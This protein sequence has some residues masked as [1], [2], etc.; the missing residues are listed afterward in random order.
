V[1]R[2]IAG[3]A[4]GL[5]LLL[6]AP[7]AVA[8]DNVPPAWAGSRITTTASV[9]TNKPVISA[10][11]VRA[12]N[13]SLPYQLNAIT[14]FTTPSGLP[15]GC[16][17]A[18]VVEYGTP[19]VFDAAS[20]TYVTNM[21]ADAPCNGTYTFKVTATLSRPLTPTETATLTGRVTVA[22][23]PPEVSGVDATMQGGAVVI[24]WKTLSSPPPDFTGYV[25]QRQTQ[26]GEYKTIAT[27]GPSATTFTDQSPPPEGGET[28]YRV[29]ATRNGPNGDIASGGGGRSDPVDLPVTT[30]STVPGTPT[31]DGGA[32]TG[33]TAGTAGTGGATSGADGGATDGGTSGSGTGGRRSP[34]TPARGSTGIGIPSPRLGSSSNSGLLLN[35]DEGFDEEI[36]YGEL[37]G[38]EAADPSLEIFD[39]QTGRGLVVPIGIGSVLFG[40]GLHLFFLARA[41]RPTMV[42]ATVA[43]DDGYGATFD[44]DLYDDE[45][46]DVYSSPGHGSYRPGSR[47]SYG[48]PSTYPTPSSYGYSSF[49]SYDDAD[50]GW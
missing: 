5:G 17:A 30:T 42:P 8:Q 37:P 11:F 31:T 21:T 14:T 9:T 27:V 43:V 13:R 25:V 22:A 18:G 29:L 49:S 50:D 32:T 15:S 16:P 7:G 12:I 4:A 1:R 33:G 6:G 47:S 23:P 44:D 2:W 36:D 38:D 34:R 39:E 40:W 28:V 45:Y 10:A 26:G 20:N 41:A 3:A 24:T 46:D 19:P 48:T 35:P